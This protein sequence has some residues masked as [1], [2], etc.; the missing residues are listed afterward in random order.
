MANNF[1]DSFITNIIDNISKEPI[2]S[3]QSASNLINIETI[4]TDIQ[5]TP[6]QSGTTFM[7]L[8]GSYTITLPY[9]IDF[10]ITPGLFYRFVLIENQDI[11][12]IITINQPDNNYNGTL[13]QPGLSDN[14][15]SYFNISNS[16]QPNLY[17]FESAK[18]G[19]FYEIQALSNNF[20]LVKGF[21]SH[22]SSLF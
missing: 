13:I 1:N 9:N 14:E 19:D 17:F 18:R 4:D 16:G 10:T 22:S 11:N 8:P 15:S 20:W 6:D 5:I 3:T 21:G 12:N 2:V 7:V